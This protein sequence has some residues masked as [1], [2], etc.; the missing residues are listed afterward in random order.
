VPLQEVPRPR[1]SGIAR[2]LYAINHWNL[3][4]PW[5]LL[6]AVVWGLS[7]LRRLEPFYLVLAATSF[8]LAVVGAW[9]SRRQ[10]TI[11]KFQRTPATP[12]ASAGEGPVHIHGRLT[13]TSDLVT[14]P[15]ERRRCVWFSSR[16]LGQRGKRSGGKGSTQSC[17]CILSDE[18]GQIDI[19]FENVDHRI[20]AVTSFSFRPG[21]DSGE[22][23]G[24]LRQQFGDEIYKWSALTYQEF[25]IEE[26]VPLHLFGDL[27]T[28][29]D[30][31]R[32]LRA[33]LAIGTQKPRLIVENEGAALG[34]REF[35]RAR[36]SLWFSSG[37]AA[38]SLAL[39]ILRPEF[40]QKR[41]PPN[42]DRRSRHRRLR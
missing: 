8:V 14:S 28:S 32:T 33:T 31:R 34:R 21:R 2:T 13:P 36:I 19:D 1:T 17:T 40:L 24:F 38:T 25:V 27:V 20:A 6:I 26:G 9:Y 18:T 16:Y 37:M 4:H 42:L 30:G 7:L 11:A 12:I 29:P 5:L 39:V 15:W 41:P 23:E 35:L 10:F 22:K 3:R